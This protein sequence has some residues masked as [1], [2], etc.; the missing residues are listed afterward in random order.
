MVSERKVAE[1]R[2]WLDETREA[3]MKAHELEEQIKEGYWN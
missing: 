2:K 1:I 3:R